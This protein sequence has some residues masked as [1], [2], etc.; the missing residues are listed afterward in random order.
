MSNAPDLNLRITGMHCA[1]CVSNI[2]KGVSAIDG[3]TDCR[4]NLATGSAQVSFDGKE[5]EAN[6]VIK[7]IEQ[8]GF[9]AQIG[10][11]DIF[12]T[13]RDEM[14]EGR[15]R[16]SVSFALSVPLMAVSMWPMA[17]GA[18]LVSPTGDGLIQAG[19]A[20][21]VLLLAGRSILSDAWLQTTHFRANMNSLIAMGTLV[22]FS[23]SCW[24]LYS[25]TMA[26]EIGVLYFDSVGMIITLILIGRMLEARS[27]GQAGEAIRALMK[28]QPSMTTAIING[29]EIEIEA[30]VAQV[31]MT[32]IVKPGERI[33]ADGL[34]SE[35]RPV[36]D[37][38][39][40]TGESLPIDKRPGKSVIGGS[41]NGHIPFQMEV[42]A[43][44][45]DSFLSSVIRMVADAQGHK[46]P[47]QQLA[48]RVAAIF[49]P[50]VIGIAAVTVAVWY[51]YAPDSDMM[52]RSGIAVLIIACPCA[53][54][55]ATPTAILAA[56]GRAAKEGIIIRGG[57]VLQRLTEIDTVVF[58]KTGTLTAGEL[59][60]V[61]VLT[62]GHISERNLL[63]AVGTAES[64]S[65]HPLARAIVR[66]MKGQLI[67]PT[68]VKNVE[69]RP[70]FGLT[71]ECDGRDLIV[72]NKDM[73]EEA[74]VSFGQS[75]LQ[76]RSQMTKGRTVVFVAMDG[77][78]VGLIAMADRVRADAPE[79][80]SQLKKM[81]DK[82]TI[83]SGDSYQ[84]VQAVAQ[85]VGIDYFEAEVKPA[86][87]KAIVESYGKVGWKVAMIGDGINDA[88]ALAS[89]EVGVAIGSG[90]DVAI[91]TGSVV[92]VRPELKTVVIM[93]DLSKAALRIIRQNLF[94]AFFYNAAAIP[95]AAGLFYPAF[96]WS[97]SPSL[98]ALAMAFSS[99][100]VVTNSLRLSR[101][102]F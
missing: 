102:Q 92:L 46:A 56:T 12:D 33:P 61:S 55:L 89:A 15:S 65:E 76:A 57:D 7:K 66:H 68:V 27:K 62:F 51:I 93:F 97:L 53:L 98:A 4:V 43:V 44:G 70:G 86:Q 73:M 14:Q 69:A 80:V 45:A 24:E 20:L 21:L 85:T 3:V 11:G 52:I 30:A 79:T 9:G 67:E 63:R 23:W 72:G 26:G 25:V 60:V 28:L 42:T 48:D 87:K 96:G 82:V 41:L 54:G 17:I 71:A 81:M 16:L 35:G 38:S 8:L 10:T 5:I 34:I 13:N 75:L 1:S 50:V 100:F 88:P 36:V 58:D 40:L 18:N 2:E 64:R 19:L 77:Q 74:K 95:V 90:T 31:G 22:A 49:V 59:E 32:L 29:V 37:E 83:L 99:V 101:L 39:M 47:I 78:V 6:L 84:T 91:E 94:W